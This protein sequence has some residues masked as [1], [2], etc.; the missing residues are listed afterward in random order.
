MTSF[1]KDKISNYTSTTMGNYLLSKGTLEK[2][3]KKHN[4]DICDDLIP[5][6]RQYLSPEQ[7]T[8]DE[9]LSEL[10]NLQDEREDRYGAIMRIIKFQR[11]NA[12]LTEAQE[13]ELID[14]KNLQ[15]LI[16][17]V[18]ELKKWMEE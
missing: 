18:E 9:V 13:M 14:F 17:E 6:I 15:I 11:A 1:W 3:F 5:R 8:V 16:A 12:K 7:K 4:V 2:Y 10:V